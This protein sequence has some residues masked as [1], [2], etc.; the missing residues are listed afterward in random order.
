MNPDRD[1][2]ERYSPL[3]IAIHWIVALCV[4]GLV[5]A[6]L[7][8]ARMNEGAAQDRL[9]TIHV[10]VGL[11]VLALSLL[12]VGMFLAGRMPEPANVLTPF[13]RTMS[14]LAH[15]TMYL[16]LIVTPWIGWLGVN[17]YGDDVTFFDLVRMPSLA[18]RDENLSN[19]LFVMHFAC[20]LLIASVVVAHLTGALAHALRRDGVNA[21]MRPF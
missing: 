7:V 16:L 19:E 20:A 17:A 6:G 12:R 10:S 18:A 13:E 15:A 5:P 9:Y 14:R 21:R 8:M 1:G 3:A 2:T 4:I 11:I